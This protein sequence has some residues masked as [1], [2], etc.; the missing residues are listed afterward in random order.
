MKTLS[1]ALAVM[2]F[3]ATACFAHAHSVPHRWAPALTMAQ[4]RAIA[5]RRAPGKIK[6]AEYERE[7]GGWR[8]SFDIV[9]GNRIHEIGVDAATGRIVED[10][11]E[12][13]GSKD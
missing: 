2:A 5:L 1:M 11:F 10:A 7:G 6:D 3:C 9:Q 13:L 4:A 12:P 8:Y